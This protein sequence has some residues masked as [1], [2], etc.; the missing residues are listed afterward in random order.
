MTVTTVTESTFPSTPDCWILVEENYVS[1]HPGCIKEYL[2]VSRDSGSL[3]SMTP[4]TSA[5]T[6]WL[7]VVSCL[8][9]PQG[10]GGSITIVLVILLTT[11]DLAVQI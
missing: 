3:G 8:L 9:S 2:V 6:R 10:V 1:T 5:H 11:V 4:D 7:G